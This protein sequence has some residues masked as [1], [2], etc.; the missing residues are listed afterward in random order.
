M[1]KMTKNAADD[2]LTIALEGR[3]DTNTAPDLEKELKESTE[4]INELILDLEKL[5]YI[6][7]AGLRVLLAAQ[8]T[9]AKKGGMKLIHV[10]D[11]IMEI[12]D[13]TGF[14]DILE[15]E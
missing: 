3:L 15:I 11:L 5:E 14:V 10:N 12:L 8:K 6:S 7:S 13:V 1:L 4:G 9:M 2:V